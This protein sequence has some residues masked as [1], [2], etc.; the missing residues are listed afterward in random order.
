[1]RARCV[2][3]FWDVAE[4]VRREPG[5]EWECGGERLAAI[6]AAGYGPL[7]EEVPVPKARPKAKAKGA[8]PA[9]AEG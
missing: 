6:N 8:A 2:N 4:R 5:D 9:G 1:M 7:A 3:P